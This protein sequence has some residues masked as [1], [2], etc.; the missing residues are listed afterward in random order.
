MA[1]K[2]NREGSMDCETESNISRSPAVLQP[3]GRKRSLDTSDSTHQSPAGA[4]PKKARNYSHEAVG[5]NPIA[6]EKASKDVEDEKN[7]IRYWTKHF[8]W[9]EKYCARNANDF[10]H[11][12]ARPMSPRQQRP[13]ALEYAGEASSTSTSDDQNPR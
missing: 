9:P 4:P 6:Q 3:N 12:L 10:R 7:P 5:D 2:D 11:L 13:A 8:K 1:D